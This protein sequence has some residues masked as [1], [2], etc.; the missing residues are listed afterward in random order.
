VQI[1]TVPAAPVTTVTAAPPPPPAVS[2]GGS[3]PS[4]HYNGGGWST[5]F[6]LA[7]NRVV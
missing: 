7:H 4:G 1:I 5:A 2:V 3:V 6:V